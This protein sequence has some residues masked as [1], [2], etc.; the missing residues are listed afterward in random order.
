MDVPI[1]PSSNALKVILPSSQANKLMTL[2][3]VSD[4]NDHDVPVGR[5]YDGLDWETLHPLLLDIGCQE[6]SCLVEIPAY[7][8]NGTMHYI[9]QEYTP[10][11]ASNDQIFAKLLLQGTYGPTMESLAEAKNL[12][13]AAAWVEDQM[14]KSPSL[15]REHYRRRTN[16]YVKND[17][18]H[19]GTRLACEKGS[20]WNRHAFNR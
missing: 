2:S 7:T 6:G 4:T 9:I 12:G 18:H 19:H 14:N 13:S 5:S 11:I 10:P 16:G 8:G 1:H 3:Q 17:L 20:R 15:L